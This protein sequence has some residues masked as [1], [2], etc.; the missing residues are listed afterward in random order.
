MRYGCANGIA[1]FGGKRFFRHGA[2]ANHVYR[3]SLGKQER[4]RLAQHTIAKLHHEA[5]HPCHSRFNYDLVVVSCGGAITALRLN[6]RQMTVICQLHFLVIEAELTQKLNPA[7]FE[8]DEIVRVI[9][10]AH[11][12]GLSVANANRA[13]GRCMR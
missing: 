6:H 10:N 2:I 12:V 8:P 11:L 1:V 5:A 3:L 9:D 7:N 13:A 4:V